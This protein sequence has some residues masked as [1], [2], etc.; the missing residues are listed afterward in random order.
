MVTVQ[1]IAFVIISA[2]LVAVLMISFYAKLIK[3]QNM[4]LS[5]ALKNIHHRADDPRCPCLSIP[6]NA[7]YRELFDQVQDQNDESSNTVQN[8][9]KHT[10]ANK[11]YAEAVRTRH[12]SHHMKGNIFSKDELFE[13]F[14]RTVLD[15]QKCTSKMDQLTVIMQMLKYAV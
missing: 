14:S 13:I 15:L 2:L 7:R 5:N 6:N 10:F 4:L 3:H 12:R 1:K 9:N 8:E 11:S